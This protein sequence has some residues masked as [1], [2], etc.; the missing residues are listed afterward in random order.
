MMHIKWETCQGMFKTLT[1][2]VEG[3]ILIKIMITH[4]HVY[5]TLTNFNSG[6]TIP[7]SYTHLVLQAHTLYVFAAST[8][9]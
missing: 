5:T 9:M 3:E 1:T 2:I 8:K 6:E 4:V 7:V